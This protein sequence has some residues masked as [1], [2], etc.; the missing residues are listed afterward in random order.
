MNW[1]EFLSTGRFTAEIREAFRERLERLGLSRLDASRRL[2]VTIPTIEKWLHGPTL[3]CGMAGRRCLTNFLGQGGGEAL[4]V[5]EDSVEYGTDEEAEK[6]RSC[7]QRLSK[8]ANECYQFPEQREH[9]LRDVRSR[10]TV[11]LE[12]LQG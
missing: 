2:G 1:E 12:R 10:H 6:F 3:H 5:G 4:F 7:L 8:I 11:I 9:F